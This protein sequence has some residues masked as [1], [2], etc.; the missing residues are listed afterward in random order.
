MMISVILILGT[1]TTIGIVFKETVKQLPTSLCSPFIDPSNSILLIKVITIGIGILQLG[2]S[3]LICL[4]YCLLVKNLI[5]TQQTLNRSVS[6]NK[7]NLITQV[8]IVTSSNLICWIPSNIIY[9]STLFM[10]KYPTD[11]L[12]WTTIAVTP[13]NSIT[14]PLVFVV[15]TLKNNALK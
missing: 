12:I 3:I 4:I 9:I 2:T 7:F 13:I 6:F 10:L 1:S 11:L 15:S 5:K 14:N 8:L